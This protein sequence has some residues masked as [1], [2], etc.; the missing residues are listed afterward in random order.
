[1]YKIVSSSDRVHT[2][3]LTHFKPPLFIFKTHSVNSGRCFTTSR[4]D[5][6]WTRTKKKTIKQTI[7]SKPVMV[8]RQAYNQ[9]AASVETLAGGWSLSKNPKRPSENSDGRSHCES[10]QETAA[11]IL[12]AASPRSIP[13]CCTQRINRVKVRELGEVRESVCWCNENITRALSSSLLICSWAA[14]GEQTWHRNYRALLD[15]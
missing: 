4:Y 6:C 9:R 13:K 12:R 7:Q 14:D 5:W 8:E 2:A 1:M 10:F 15:C 11:W 3:D